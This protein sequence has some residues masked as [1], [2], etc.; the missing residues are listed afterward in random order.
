MELNVIYNEDC[1]EGI[2]KIPDKSVDLVYIDVPYDL[3]GNGGGAF[4][5]KKRD[6]HNEYEQV[7]KNTNACRIWKDI[8]KNHQQIKDIAFGI[9]YSILDELVRVM[10]KIYIYMVQ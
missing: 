8:V 2:K 5:S 1:Y 6:Y 4:G 3:E 10:K 7:S 9:D